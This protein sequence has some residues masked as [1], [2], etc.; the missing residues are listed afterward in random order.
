MGLTPLAALFLKLAESLDSTIHNRNYDQAIK[1]TTSTVDQLLTQQLLMVLLDTRAY[2]YAM[3]GQMELAI[4]DAHKM[5]D[6]PSMLPNG[7][8]RKVSRHFE[9]AWKSTRSDSNI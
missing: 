6:C 9:N 8:L 3:Q 1:Y 2:S 7:Y 4:V 5:M